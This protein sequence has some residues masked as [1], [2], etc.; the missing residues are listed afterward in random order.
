[1]MRLLFS[2]LAAVPLFA[3]AS[4]A[5]AAN[6]DVRVSETG[7]D[8]AYNAVEDGPRSPTEQRLAFQLPDG[9]EIELVAA[10]SP[11]IG[12][13]VTVDWDA[14]M[15][16]WSMTALEYPVDGNEDQAASDALF[17]RGGRDRV[18][19]FDAPYAAPA[20]PGAAT[21]TAPPR[22]FADALVMPLGLLPYR[23]GALVQYGPD[24]RFYRDTD[25]DG[26]A[27]RHEVVLTGFGTQDS[28]LFPHQFL[29]QPGGEFFLAQGLFNYSTLRRPGDAP[30]ADGR[31][32]IPY[33]QC[34]LAVV[35]LDGSRFE[36]VTAGP[37]NIWGLVT[38]RDG[39]TFLQEANDQGYPVIP[40]MPGIHVR[41]GS[42]DKLRPYQ[43]LM[44]PPL[45]PAQMGGTGLSG[46]AL[47]EDEE[48]FFRRTHAS[49]VPD[50][51]LFY[52]ANPITGAIQ[53]VRA[54]P[55]GRRYR[56][57]KRADFL[58]S[59]DRWFRPVAVHFGPDGCL[60]VVDWYNKIISHNEVPRG[61]P[62]RD[63]VRG[64]IWRV[65]HRDQPRIV[66]PDLTRLEDRA[67]LAHL[68]GPNA[69]V[70]RFAW[71]QIAD[72][73]AVALAPELAAIV[74]DAGAPLP[75]RLGALWALEDVAPIATP[76]LQRIS[77]DAAPQ[78]R[79]EAARILGAQ[80]R[81]ETEFVALATPL[82]DDPHPRVRAAIGHALRRVPGGG[83]ALVMLAA[84]LGREPLPAGTNLDPA[85]NPRADRTATSE[86]WDR[87]DREFERFLARWAME[88][89]PEATHALLDSAAGQA[90][91][92]ESRVLASLALQG[93]EAALRL[94]KLIPD[95]R[96]PLNDEEI[97]ALA[98]HAA[99]L[100]VR[101]AL[102][103][104]L[105]QPGSRL[106]V[107]RGLLG[108]RTSLDTSA[109]A[110]ALTAAA[111]ELLD[112]RDPT[113]VALGAELAG[114]FKLSEVAPLLVSTLRGAWQTTRTAT[115]ARG[116]LPAPALAALRALREIG[117]GPLD[118]FA[119]LAQHGQPATLRDE[120]LHALAAQKTPAAAERL[121]ALFPHLSVL[122][123]GHAIDRL[124]ENRVTAAALLSGLRSNTVAEA[125]LGLKTVEKLRAVLPDDPQ[126]AALWG[127]V[128]SATQRALRLP[129]GSGDYV[130]LPSD[131]AGPF[132]IECWLKLEREIDA[133]DVLLSAPGQLEL[134]FHEG[135][136]TV[137]SGANANVI[138]AARKK[139]TPGAW[140]HYALTRDAADLFSL[141]IAGEPDATSTI[142]DTNTFR[143]LALGRGPA[144]DS[145]L[146][147]WLTEFRLWRLARSARDIRENFDRSLGVGSPPGLAYVLG[148]S[149]WTAELHGAAQIAPS[150]DA[151]ALL[152]ETEA[153]AQATKFARFRALARA[154]GDADRGKPLFSALCLT[155]HQ[156]GGS[157]GT[158]A[159][160][161]DGLGHTDVETMLRNIL[162][163]NAALES[164]YRSFRIVTQD[165][166]V[167]EGFLAEET[168]DAIVLR[169][170]GATERRIPQ[171]EIRSRGFVG[172]S[173]MPEG[174]LE[175]LGGE[176]VS[177]LFAYLKSLK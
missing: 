121:V 131:L 122:Q 7:R 118:L 106:A 73:N 57:E 161:L 157:G 96:R 61:H 68:G 174:L 83:A 101:D 167:Q 159:P 36:S 74:S 32:A 177:D 148:R 2:P 21:V 6:P 84:K 92:L 48:D 89:K 134:S 11:G 71:Q 13:F 76:L 113:R 133:R 126:V 158:L 69:L 170:P 26:R 55:E 18:V 135:R 20:A 143:G 80:P 34:K 5:L 146:A 87:Y 103:Q 156:Q 147:G 58:T 33:N 154:P 19:V 63:K 77:A 47:A 31:T 107:L 153:S 3:S 169:M 132:T 51:K 59:T 176:Q 162:T 114:A 39:E 97:R 136:F 109:F 112:D 155:C 90:M 120:A 44:P 27:D 93:K 42:R 50:T 79:H 23:D 78:L 10:E 9:F 171:R 43:P 85:G 149:H 67:L 137:R 66:P 37:N 75:R 22:I 70:A 46:L 164:A 28:H 129:G 141:Y 140:T 4:W 111:G 14:R 1:M 166:S 99:E 127:K 102:L 12:K 38:S 49:E 16:L 15:R 88:T 142:K 64:R 105:A 104:A 128:G 117:E 110:P 144:A 119:E 17:A 138:V 35:A 45:A 130:A 116:A 72:R 54:T 25:G 98:H 24:L 108:L 82:V 86:D 52:L 65:R 163:P 94:T 165:G 123:R 56:Y 125:D 100:P 95:L 145:G 29:R 53:V 150:D 175:S 41:T 152:T 172:R 62:E 160:P 124:A 40:Y 81:P 173:L 139:A 115:K 168:A 91:P 60:Y 151:P 8:I 30:F